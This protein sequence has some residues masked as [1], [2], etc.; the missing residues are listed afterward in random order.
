VR[1]WR[2]FSA[3][4]ILSH[5]RREMKKLLTIENPEHQVSH[6]IADALKARQKSHREM[7]D[8]PN[9]IVR[10]SEINEEYG[11][12]RRD[13]YTS[14]LKPLGLDL[15]KAI[16]RLREAKLAFNDKTATSLRNLLDIKRQRYGIK[17]NELSYKP[18]RP[19]LSDPNFWAGDWNAWGTSDSQ[20]TIV[21]HS[22][23]IHF[24]GGPEVKKTNVDRHENF[25]AITTFELQHERIP[26]STSGRWTSNPFVE[27]FGGI[28][29]FAPDF[30]VWSGHG[31][32]S[33]DLFLRQTLFQFFI[34]PTG[35]APVVFAEAVSSTTLV[36]LEDTGYSRNV[37]LPG[38]QNIPS[39]QFGKS[40]VKAVADPI[41][42]EIE[43]RFDI[44]M[45]NAGASVWCDP[46]VLM[47]FFQWPLV[48]I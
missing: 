32:A 9:E 11:N 46:E 48:A 5:V 39:V 16:D 4:G 13:I 33:C 18:G 35:R 45:K 6:E 29:A 34:S 23:G 26:S 25:G 14:L 41:W 21:Q 2:F 12:A 37:A 3:I 22:D 30:D 31:I 17:V 28:M 10:A 20:I 1:V 36:N 24:S 42:A 47:R 43:V 40:D 38:H 44:Y 27:L 15:D 8:L 19:E 7:L